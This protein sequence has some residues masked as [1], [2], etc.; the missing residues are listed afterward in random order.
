[1]PKVSKLQEKFS[2]G[3]ISKSTQ[4]RVSDDHYDAALASAINYLPIVQGPLVRRPGTRFVSYTK[5]YSQAPELIP[6]QFSASENYVLEFGDKYVRFYTNEGQVVTSSNS[7]SVAGYFNPARFSGG[8]RFVGI[9]PVTNAGFT[10]TI[11][12]SSLVSPGSILE[13]PTWYSWVDLKKIKYTQKQDVMYLTHPSYPPSKLIR[14]GLNSWDLKQIQFNDGPYLPL[15]SY[16][17]I[18][19]AANVYFSIGTTSNSSYINVTTGQVGGATTNL[20]SVIIIAADS[21][22]TAAV[23]VNTAG[24]HGFANG[25]AVYI[26][27]VGQY[28]F[29]GAD[30]V[31][32][33]SVSLTNSGVTQAFWLINNVTAN[34]FIIPHVP[35]SGIA[36]SAY[37]TPNAVLFPALMQLVAGSSGQYWADVQVGSSTGSAAGNGLRSIGFICSDGARRYGQIQ[38]VQDAAHFSVYLFPGQLLPGGGLVSSSI[39]WQLGTYNYINGF[40]SATC[41]HQDRLVFAGAKGFPQEIDASMTGQYE[42]FSASGS[43]LQVTANN[44][45]QFSLSA[46]DLNAVRWIKSNAQG[47]VAGTASGEWMVSASTQNPTLTPTSISANQA[48]FFG[49]ADIDALVVNNSV[50]YIQRAQRKVRELIYQW[51]LQTFRS[52]NV[53]E[54]SESVVAPQA[55]KLVAQKEPHPQI[56]CLKSDGQMASF[57][58]QRDDQTGLTRSGWAR[59]KLG[60]QSDAAA[61]APFVQSLAAIPSG[62]AT[63]DELWL[64]VNR[65]I[66]G[67]TVACIEYMNK[68][69][70]DVT[71]QEF[72]YH[73]DCGVTYNSSIIVTGISIG[74]STVITAPNH[75]LSNSTT[76]RFYNTVGLN[77]TSTDVNGNSQSSNI[78]NE[79]TFWVQSVATNTFMVQDFI[80]NFINTNS[81]GVYVGSAVIKKLVTSISGLSWLAGETVSVLA[82]GGIHVN[83]SVTGAGIL[84]LQYPAAVVSVG[85]QY[86]SDGQMLRTKDGSAQ[87]SSIGSTRRVN[88]VAFLMHNVGDLS[89]GSTF[90]NLIPAE[91]IRAD[92]N[93]ADTMVPLFDGIHR[94]GIESSYGFTDSVCFRQNSGL[95]GMIQ[96]ITRFYE[97]F[98]V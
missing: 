28:G 74:S 40:P 65:Y 2:A 83:T 86:N 96:A 7:F 77:I 68:H 70:D 97:E 73:F 1:M 90:T 63:Y 66:Q 17:S 50:V 57:T 82:D 26:S 59:H 35:V 88:R 45:L 3:E 37:P 23:Q 79:Q 33:A 14:T 5:N 41:F 25:D 91:F 36:G 11:T 29:Q 44:A 52:N 60:G 43:N 27:G 95:P 81:G 6:F 72:S 54:L 80:G 69:F 20:S 15:N 4:G 19:D 22:S 98:D 39:F 75:G 85:Y 12:A 24:A 42:A 30:N 38:S 49:V 64:S 58:I 62:D 61:T 48:A 71:P 92:A 53:S 16:K 55:I 94:D 10:E 32:S 84:T 31:T 13:L 93:S 9:R 89:F 51:Q 67:T 8:M 56:W 47:L 18:A 76:V 34:S 46:Q 87:G 21:P 78:F